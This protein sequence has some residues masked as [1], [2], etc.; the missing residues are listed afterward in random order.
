MSVL[1][2]YSNEEVLEKTMTKYHF[3]MEKY[4]KK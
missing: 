3:D 1:F 2:V 4:Q